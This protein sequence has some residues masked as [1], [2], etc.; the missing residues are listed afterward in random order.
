MGAEGFNIRLSR[1]KVA[2]AWEKCN[3]VPRSLFNVNRIFSVE[4]RAV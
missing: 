3:T 2:V 1:L 4:L